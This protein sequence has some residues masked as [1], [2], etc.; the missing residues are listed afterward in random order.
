M[1]VN[2]FYYGLYTSIILI[3]GIG[4]DRSIW[5][6]KGN[7]HLLLSAV[8]ML[9]CVCSSSVLSYLFVCFFLVPADLGELYPFFALLIYIAI[10]VIVDVIIRSQEKFSVSDFFAALFFVLISQGES[11]T[12]IECI[13]M[14]CTCVIAY[15]L[16]IPFLKSFTACFNVSR[17][18]SET[19]KGVF[20]LVTLAFITLFFLAWNISWFNRR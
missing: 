6:S 1:I 3:Y 4:L 15:S 18:K 19:G 2:V 13:I 10:S 5:L 12:L 7:E 14:S 8:K 20:I 17:T 9:I 11:A 16:F